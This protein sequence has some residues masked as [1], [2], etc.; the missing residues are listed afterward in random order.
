MAVLQRLGQPDC[1]YET[2]VFSIRR[3]LAGFSN[4][5]AVIEYTPKDMRFSSMYPFRIHYLS[6]EVYLIDIAREYD[7]SLIGQRI[8]AINGQPL[9]DVEQKLFSF[10]SAENLWT[11]RKSLDP[12]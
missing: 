9:A 12:F 11:K 5:H 4:E 1:T 8:T 6:N 7:H 10:V 3:Y 2:F